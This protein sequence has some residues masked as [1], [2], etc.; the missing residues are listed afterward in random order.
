MSDI[1]EDFKVVKM[2]S[3][4]YVDN[5]ET[6]SEKKNLVDISDENDYVERD[7]INKNYD[8]TLTDVDEEYKET[9]KINRK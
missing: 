2:G 1:L 3:H 5:V 6:E 7:D 4:K 9:D 8:V